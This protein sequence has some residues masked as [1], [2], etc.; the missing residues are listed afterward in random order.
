MTTTKLEY[1]FQLYASDL[2]R[3]APT[4]AG[5]FGCPLCYKTIEWTPALKEVVAE[6]HIIPHALGGRITTLT[7]RKCNNDNGSDLDS[8]LVQRARVETGRFP[9]GARVYIGDS[10]YG[11]LVDLPKSTSDPFDI[12]AVPKQSGRRKLDAAMHAM[13]SGET[14]FQLRI[15]SVTTIGEVSSVCFVLR[16]F[17]CFATLVTGMSWTQA[18]DRSSGRFNTRSNPR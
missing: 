16:I 9:V 10:D 14:E 2:A 11:A 12:V 5:C 1:L 7:C 8:H 4:L 18:H 13:Q 3:F 17:S 6:E 15:N